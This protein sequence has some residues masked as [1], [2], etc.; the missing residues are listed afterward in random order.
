[1]FISYRKAVQ[2]K[3]KSPWMNKPTEQVV[4]DFRFWEGLV[5][6]FVGDDPK[7]SSEKTGPETIE[8]P[9]CKTD[10]A[11]GKGMV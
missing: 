8:R 2:A 10:N 1:M 3:K 11:V 9:K 7:A 6:A 4:Y 5:T